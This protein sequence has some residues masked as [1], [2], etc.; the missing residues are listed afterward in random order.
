MSVPLDPANLR[1]GDLV[2]L[3]ARSGLVHHVGLYSGGGWVIAAPHQGALVSIEPLAAAPWD[4]F[5]RIL[6][7]PQGRILSA[8]LLSGSD[9][10]LVL[11]RRHGTHVTPKAVRTPDAASTI[12]TTPVPDRSAPPPAPPRRPHQIE[13][14]AALPR[15]EFRHWGIGLLASFRGAGR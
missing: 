4:G 15:E 8:R 6:K 2:F 5:G 13:R 1:P 9:H 3:G 7:A 10:R 14:L 12:F 11:R